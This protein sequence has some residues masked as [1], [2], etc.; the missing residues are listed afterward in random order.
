MKLTRRNFMSSA[1]AAGVAFTIV[2]SHVLGGTKHIAPSEKLNIAGIGAG[3]MA[4][5]NLKNCAKENIVALCD[6]DDRRAA[7]AYK[8]FSTAKRF[9]DFRVMLDKMGKDIDAVVVATP[10]HTHAV[11]AM[12]AIKMGKHAYVQKPLTRTVYEA[13]MLTEAARKAGVATQMGNQGHSWGGCRDIKEWI[14]DGAIGEVKEVHCWT[15]RPVWAQGVNR[16]TETPPVP[17]GLDWD[18]WLG[19]AAMRPYHQTYLPFGWRAWYDFGAG[20]LGDMGCHIMDAAFM[21]LDLKYPTSVQASRS[22]RMVP[23][24]ETG[25][26]SELVNNDTFPDSSIVHYSFPSRGDMPPVKVHWYDGG[27]LPERPEELPENR[28]LPASGSLFVGD[29]GKIMAGTYGTGPRLLPLDLHKSYK[30]PEKTI[31]RIKGSH[32]QNWIDACK[33]GDPASSNFDYSGP[34]TEMIVMGN[35]AIRMPGKLLKW[36]GINMKVTNNEE[37][38]AFV[39]PVYRDGWSL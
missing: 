39:K 18:L 10:D 36:D 22:R 25:F 38:N 1:A 7:D 27:L 29:K 3:G 4:F 19:P 2:P 16:P 11:A 14:A 37:A 15:N 33:G 17:E 8:M 32:E 26:G 12:K 21:A 20:A 13:R 28:M 5:N 6:V 23:N 31:K 24:Y 30:R 9:K 35:F 34:F